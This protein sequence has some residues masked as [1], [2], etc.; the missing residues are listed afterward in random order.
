[1]RNSLLLCAALLLAAMT[2]C[3]HMNL[4]HN[5]GCDNC[6]GGHAGHGHGGHA[7]GGGYVGD[8]G[9]GGYGGAVA[10][11]L[12]YRGIHYGPDGRQDG[13]GGG[14]YGPYGGPHGTP[15][16]PHHHRTR[17]YTGPQGPSTAQVAYP[18][19]TTRGPRD[20]FVDNP[21]SIGP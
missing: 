16:Y 8:G 4:A 17:E 20:F 21:P 7:H 14:H 11:N 9:A 2:G 13:G 5:K 19:Y 10:G 12:P 3:G 6:F 15:G 18:Y 1:M